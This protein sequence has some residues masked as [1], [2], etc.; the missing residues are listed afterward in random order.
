MEKRMLGTD[1]PL[2]SQVGLGCMGMSDLYSS[3]DRNEAIATIQIALDAGISLLDTG[4]F[5]GMRRNE[6]LIRDALAG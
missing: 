2:V 6:L 1:G 4:D 5:Y 3:A